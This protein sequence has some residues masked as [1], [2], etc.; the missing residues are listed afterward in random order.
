MTQVCSFACPTISQAARGTNRRAPATDCWIASSL[1]DQSSCMDEPGLFYPRSTWEKYATSS[2]ERLPNWPGPRS[3]SR[4]VESDRVS[5]SGSENLPTEPTSKQYHVRLNSSSDSV[6][7]RGWSISVAKYWACSR[8]NT[9]A[10]SRLGTKDEI[11]G[12]K[13]QFRTSY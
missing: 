8:L 10:L 3:R 11:S 12:V 6:F 5:L 9:P 2:Q 4:I 1:D 13:M 7:G